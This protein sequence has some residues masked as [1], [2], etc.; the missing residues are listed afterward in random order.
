M[1]GLGWSCGAEA[2]NASLLGTSEQT[3][4]GRGGGRTGW[5]LQVAGVAGVKVP[6]VGMPRAVTE[7][8]GVRTAGG[9]AQRRALWTRRRCGLWSGAAVW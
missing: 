1:A 7:K 9:A 8:P 4:E 3:Q 2:G 5:V 6:R